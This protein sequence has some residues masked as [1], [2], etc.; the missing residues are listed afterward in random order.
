MDFFVQTAQPFI[1]C[2]HSVKRRCKES[3]WR[4]KMVNEPVCPLILPGDVKAP[5]ENST[6][7]QHPEGLPER[8]FLVWEGMEAVEG[9]YQ[10]KAAVL[11]G[12]RPHIPLPEL[13]VATAIISVE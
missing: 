2:G 6:G 3:P 11:K 1:K 12:Q 10:I 5:A 7:L 4:V 13:N 9:Q 8:R